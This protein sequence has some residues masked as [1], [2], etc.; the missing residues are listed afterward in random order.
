MLSPKNFSE[1]NTLF[2]ELTAE[3]AADIN[4]GGWFGAVVGAVAGGVGG[5]FAGGPLGA[6]GGALWA[7][8]LGMR[9]RGVSIAAAEQ[10]P[11]AI[12]TDIPERKIAQ[13]WYCGGGAAPQ[14]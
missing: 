9:L 10:S 8:Q 3:E 6:V 13:G 5:F 2:T 4:G 11:R 7:L 12:V 14:C 1:D